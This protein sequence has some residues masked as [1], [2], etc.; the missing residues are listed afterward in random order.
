MGL[1]GR[2]RTAQRRQR[3]W[4]VHSGATNAGGHTYEYTFDEPGTY[5]YY[6]ETQTEVKMRGAV[7]VADS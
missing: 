6:C 7:V 3:E 4:R 2:W 1:D 5:F